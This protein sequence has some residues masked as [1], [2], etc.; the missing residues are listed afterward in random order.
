MNKTI[1][2]F[3]HA[4][5]EYNRKRII[6]GSGIDAPL[7]EMGKAQALAFF[8]KHGA[9]EF[10]AVLT[11]SLIRTHQTA[12]P[13]IDKGL[14]WEQFADINEINW[15]DHEGK[16]SEP[17]MMEDYERMKAEWRNGNYDARLANGESARELSDRVL[18]FI[19]HLKTRKENRLLVCSHGRTMRCIMCHIKGEEVSEMD[20]YHHKNTG[21]YIIHQKDGRFEVEVEN[22]TS[23]L[24][25]VD[26]FL[27]NT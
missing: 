4:E 24:D 23:H 26:H 1:Y 6:Q 16:K 21:L 18:R 3:R 11:S 27:M 25:F 13:F 2:L 5:T 10:D 9:I 22:D 7:N 15:G 8:K 20:N 19:T 14:I 12:R 17:W